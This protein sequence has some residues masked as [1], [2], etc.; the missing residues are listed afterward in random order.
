MYKFHKAGGACSSLEV[1]AQYLS[2][3]PHISHEKD[4]QRNI[5]I[6]QTLAYKYRCAARNGLLKIN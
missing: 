4:G 1:K 3:P 6:H 5:T 2:G